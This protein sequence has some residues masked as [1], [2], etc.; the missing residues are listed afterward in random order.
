MKRLLLVFLLIVTYLTHAQE[1]QDTEDTA[2]APKNTLEV[3]G[4]SVLD[5]EVSDSL[6]IDNDSLALKKEKIISRRDSLLFLNFWLPK[7]GVLKDVVLDTLTKI[8]DSITKNLTPRFKYMKEIGLE[9]DTRFISNSLIIQLLDSFSFERTQYNLRLRKAREIA[10]KPIKEMEEVTIEDYKIYYSDGTVKHVDTT[11]TI[12]KDYH[13]NYLRKDYFE[14]LPFANSGETFNKLGYDFQ[15]QKIIPDIGA[16]AKHYGYMEKDEIGYYEVPSP[17]TELFFKTVFEQGQLVDALITVNTAPRLNITLAHKAFRSLGNYINTLGGG[18]NLRF[19]SQY[20]TKNYRYRQRSHFA[21]QRIENQANGGLDSLSVYYFE[22]AIDELEYDGFLDRSRLTNN[23]N[24]NNTLI[25]RRYYLDHQYDA[26]LGGN[27]KMKNYE[28]PKVLTIGHKFNFE[29]KHFD[30]NNSSSNSFF[31]TVSGTSSFATRNSLDVMDN[32]IYAIYHEK[33]LGELKAGLRLIQWN[34]S[35]KLPENTKDPDNPFDYGSNPTEIKANQLALSAYWKKTFLKFDFKAE[36][37]FSAVKEYS[38][39]FISGALS[40]DFENGISTKA[41]LSLRS[42][43]PNF[44]FFLHRSNFLE[45]DWYNPSL[46]NQLTNSLNFSFVHPKWGRLEGQYELLNNY[47]YFKNLKPVLRKF[48]Y[49]SAISKKEEELLVAP[50]QYEGTIGYLK[51]RFSQQLDFWKFTWAIT[52]QYQQVSNDGDIDFKPLNVPE[53][54]L[55][56]SFLFSS[57]LFNKAL[58]LQTGVTAQYFTDFYADRY[59]PH[60]GEFVSQN[61]TEIGKFPRLDFFIN[62][63]IQQTRLFLKY[64][65][66]NSD[67]TGYNFYSAPFTPYRDS[68]I[69]FGLVWNFFQ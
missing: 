40:R 47:T 50:E 5:E 21:A 22:K 44:N 9:H 46:K 63:K 41:K 23:A 35:I 29:G 26:T 25:G 52:A 61:H 69:R 67:M 48:S 30:Y 57:Q 55:R 39:Q 45:Y 62:A 2:V 24:T 31:G 68:S 37:Y 65:H 28:K 15:D 13:F 56:S 12:N 38:S 59:S 19:T 42:Q 3:M 14:L 43:A 27:D 58:Y 10:Q 33:N 1:N 16:R 6:S 36:G 8:P 54:N 32:E 7:P 34:Y 11:L 20:T 53:W 18:T 60:L 51:L 17:L 49:Y 4:F 66:F 64:E